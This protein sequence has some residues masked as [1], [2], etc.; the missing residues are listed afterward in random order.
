MYLLPYKS[1]SPLLHIV[2]AQNAVIRTDVLSR[3]IWRRGVGGEEGQN[4]RHDATVD[5]NFSTYLAESW[6]DKK[7]GHIAHIAWKLERDSVAMRAD[8]VMDHL[9]A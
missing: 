8:N 5:A 9:I 1:V 7:V 6:A 3:T 2:R 4:I